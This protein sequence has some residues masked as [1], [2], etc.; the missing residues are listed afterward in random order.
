MRVRVRTAI[1]LVGL[2]A[3]VTTAAADA[4]SPP[5]ALRVFLDCAECD[6]EFLRQQM[7]YVDWVRD[8]RDADLYV[9][10]TARSTGAGGVET[11]LFVARPRGGGPAADTLRFE[12]PPLA[13]SD[14]SRRTLMRGLQAVLARDLVGR[15]EFDQMSITVKST[16]VPA[17]AR[18]PWR[19]WVISLSA[20]GYMQ[21]QQHVRSTNVSGDVSAGRSTRS[22]K[23]SIDGY[24]SY[25]ED[26]FEFDDGTKY[27]GI[28]R[29]RGA[30]L[31][32]ASNLSSHWGIGV[33]GFYSA[34]SYSNVRD[35]SGGGMGL[36]YDFWTYEESS[37]H[38]LTV[39]YEVT[40]RWVDY[41]E[42]TLYNR[43]SERLWRHA[44]VAKLS[45]TQPWGYVSMIGETRQYLRI[46]DRY[47]VTGSTNVSFNLARGFS[48]N[49][50]GYA[51]HLRDLLSIRRAGATDEEVLARQRQI[52]T[53]YEFIVSMGV[54]YTFGSLLHSRVNPRL[55]SI[56]GRF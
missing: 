6:T 10:V 15:P 54:T 56:F 26:E 22:G 18:D 1:G 30:S 14:E 53:S 48:L 11:Q 29:G 50:S 24:G 25:D 5:G 49:A 43:T 13:S 9:L 27:L 46:R 20:N 39:A 23:I 34:S 52:D 55:N 3:A 37:R 41:E 40:G 7:D 8:R 32:S 36:E 35:E 19:G 44:L 31:R 51:A 12:T 45:V 17:L 4:A 2:T 38:L 16:R 47:S 28:R 33:R 42:I 21:G